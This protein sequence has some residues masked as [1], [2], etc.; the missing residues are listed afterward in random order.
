MPAHLAAAGTNQRGSR[1]D[2]FV[3]QL[4]EGQMKSMRSTFEILLIE[5]RQ[6]IHG[7]RNTGQNG[8]AA[9]RTATV[10]YGL[11]NASDAENDSKNSARGALPGRRN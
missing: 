7:T 10:A 8:T 1:S 5:V 11:D 3:Q 9:L 4:R 2:F 6:I